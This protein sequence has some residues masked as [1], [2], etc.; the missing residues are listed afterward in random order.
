MA[1]ALKTR[2]PRV[3]RTKQLLQ[4]DDLL[5]E[6]CHQRTLNGPALAQS[7]VDASQWQAGHCGP[8]MDLACN[9]ADRERA[10]AASIPVLFV[11][12][13]PRA[14]TRTIWAVI[15]FSING[16]LRRRT[17]THICVEGREG[18]TP[19]V[20]NRDAS[21]AIVRE[22]VIGRSQAT[23][24]HVKPRAIFGA[25]L[26]AVRQIRLA[27]ASIASATISPASPQAS[28]YDSRV[29]AAIA[30]AFVFDLPSA[31]SA[32]AQHC[33][34]AESLTRHVATTLFHAPILQLER[35]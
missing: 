1:D 30:R 33:E 13:S 21:A 12:G 7:V 8:F 19:S 3:A 25:A 11:L 24:L 26:K 9:A 16:V 2:S 4:V 18:I 5:A 6:W 35:A 14:I 32:S 20:A 10:H 31:C 27:L 28:G 29:I 34:S 17:R 23:A 22:V 15:V